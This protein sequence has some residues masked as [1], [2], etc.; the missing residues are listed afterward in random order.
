MRLQGFIVVADQRI[1]YKCLFIHDIFMAQ[2]KPIRP[3]V[4]EIVLTS[5][6]RRCAMCYGLNKDTSLKLGQV[7][8]LDGDSSNND[9]ENLA[10]LCLEHH[11][12]YDSRTFQAK[13]FIN[14]EVKRYRAELCSAITVEWNKP[15]TFGLAQIQN[16]SYESL[17]GHY[18]CEGRN[19]LAE[20]E[21]KSSPDG[22]IQV[23]GFALWGTQS[24][25]PHSGSVDFCSSL[26]DNNRVCFA[27]RDNDKW[28]GLE[29]KFTHGGLEVEEQPLP[30]YLGLNVG[31]RGKYRRV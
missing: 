25:S 2:R 15:A 26:Q 19:E 3:E 18:V 22:N 14:A 4:E 11:A 13:G 5:C 23:K 9:I 1:S 6:R 28:Y 17:S 10:F 8:H 20:F 24:M 27:D 31:F 16:N 29:I 7:A 12:A 30:G 21:I